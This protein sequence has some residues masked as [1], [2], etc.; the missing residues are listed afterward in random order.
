M[1]AISVHVRLKPP[2]AGSAPATTVDGD[3]TGGNIVVRATPVDS[4]FMTSIVTG[5]QRE[6]HEAVGRPLLDHLER[7][8]SC[9]LI[10]YGQT[11]AGKTHTV[12]GPPGS[13]NETSLAGLASG[14]AP[15]DWGL[16]PRLA[17]ALLHGGAG[18]LHASAV[19]V[20]HEK[21]YDLLA[22]RAPL[23]VGSQRAGRAV[24]GGPTCMHDLLLMTSDGF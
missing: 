6:S 15:A 21:A 11:G 1:S 7:G 5:D 12:F 2:E 23:T 22:D 4:A 14:E 9:A 16:F 18:T 20:F 8:Y 13:L 3:S 10:A 17:L 24:G 19:E